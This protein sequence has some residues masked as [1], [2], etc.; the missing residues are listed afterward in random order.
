MRLSKARGV[1]RGGQVRGTRTFPRGAGV[2]TES[3]GLG[4]PGLAPGQGRPSHSVVSVSRAQTGPSRSACLR[5]LGVRRGPSCRSQCAIEAAI[6]SAEPGRPQGGRQLGGVGTKTEPPFSLQRTSRTQNFPCFLPLICLTS[7]TGASF[8]VSCEL[9][10][11]GAPS[12]SLSAPNPSS[13]SHRLSVGPSL[14]L[15]RWGKG[16]ATRTGLAPRGTHVPQSWPRRRRPGNLCHRTGLSLM[17]PRARAGAAL[18]WESV[19]PS[20]ALCSLWT[21]RG[22]RPR[23]WRVLCVPGSNMEMSRQQHLSRLTAPS[24]GPRGVGDTAR[25]RRRGPLGPHG[26][27]VSWGASPV[28]CEGFVHNL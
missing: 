18:R 7:G 17:L 28:R 11:P 27:S 5:G 9:F 3:G 2:S 12:D 13:K 19:Y 8:P 10:E 22:A 25:G 20:P 21:E 15:R 26:A 16:A 6:R 23:S 1:V 24:S 14:A 4:V